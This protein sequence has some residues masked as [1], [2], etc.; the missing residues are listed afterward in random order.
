MA[1]HCVAC[2]KPIELVRREIVINGKTYMVPYENHHCSRRSESAKSR[3]DLDNDIVYYHQSKASRL[4]DGLE[5][6]ELY[7]N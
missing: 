7:N 3:K 6:L 5:M 1:K 4:H 2:G